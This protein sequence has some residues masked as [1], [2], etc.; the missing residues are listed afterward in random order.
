MNPIF[1]ALLKLT[2]V[3]IKGHCIKYMIKIGRTQQHIF[4]APLVP[5]IKSKNRITE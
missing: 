2:I 3:I 5:Y 4:I 1:K